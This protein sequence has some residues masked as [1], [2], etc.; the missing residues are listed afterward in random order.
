MLSGKRSYLVLV[1][2]F[3]FKYTTCDLI[4]DVFDAIKEDK[5]EVLRRI[6]SENTDS[7]D[8]FINLQ[9][10][11]SGQTPVMMSVL[12]GRTEMVGLLL[13][14]PAVDLSIG[15]MQGYTVMHG[16]GFQGRAEILR[17][18]LADERDLDPRDIHQDGFSPLH[19]ACWGNEA[20][21]TDT[22]KVFLEEAGVPWDLRSEKGTTCYDVTNNPGTRNLIRKWK[23]Q[24]EDL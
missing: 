21:H 8:S 18:L 9:D 1:I 19:R 14:Q 15:E 11:Q 4:K 10:E 16:A 3:S 13:A 7:L 12:R 2:I 20:R 17:L 5:T 6:L 24:K 22:V 23:Q